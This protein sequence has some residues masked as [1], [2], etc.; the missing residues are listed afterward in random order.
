VTP[1]PASIGERGLRARPHIG[2]DT[3]APLSK[4]TWARRGA[5][6]RGREALRRT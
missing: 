6:R 3:A 2:L 4:A 5:A 1:G